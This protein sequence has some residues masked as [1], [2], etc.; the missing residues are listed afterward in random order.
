MPVQGKLSPLSSTTKI[1]WSK[2]PNPQEIYPSVVGRPK[3]LGD[4]AFIAEGLK[5]INVG[6]NAWKYRR[7]L[8]LKY[9]IENGIIKDWEECYHLWKYGFDEMKVKPSQSTIIVTEPVRNPDENREKIAELLFEKFGFS[10]MQL[11]FQPIFSM[12]SEGKQ[13]ACVLDSG[14]GVSTV[15]PIVNNYVLNNQIK[16]NNL[17]GKEITKYL[18]KLLFLRGYAFNSSADFETVKEIKEKLGFISHN[19][20]LDRKIANETVFYDQDYVLPDGTLVKVA[21]AV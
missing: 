2:D 19:I 14:D 12:I 1:G 15:I 20:A 4:E 7:F 11:Q 17:A 21:L 5:D 13:T 3:L 8:D 18:I 6:D 10:K 16:R 9:P